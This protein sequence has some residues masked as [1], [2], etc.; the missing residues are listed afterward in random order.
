VESTGIV[1]ALT[2]NYTGYPLVRQAREMIRAGELGEIRAVRTSYFQGRRPP[3]DA[4]A[5]RRLA[6]RSDP[7][8][9]GAAGCFA[10]IGT[11]AFNLS[12]YVTG[13]FPE[14]VSCNLKILEEGRPLDDYGHAVIR[15]ENGVLGTVTASQV[16]PGRSNELSLEVDGSKGT[17]TWRQEEPNQMIVRRLD[18]PHALYTRDPKSPFLSESCTAACRL[19]AGHPEG[20]F[21]A[22]GNVYRSAFDSMVLRAT[23]EPFEKKDTVYPNVYD[24]VEGMYFIQQCV[25]SS[26]ENGAWRKLK[27]DLARR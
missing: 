20:F 4:A 10:D 27:H 5:K 19:P 25:A 11:H 13:L 18:E 26:N 17:L 21:E 12:R 14:E 6:W 22:F 7:A 9:A 16:S 24:G 3:A 8:R 2:H 15:F 23:G 1:F